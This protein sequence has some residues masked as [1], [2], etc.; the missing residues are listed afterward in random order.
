MRDVE[1]CEERVEEER[2]EGKRGKNKRK[3][4]TVFPP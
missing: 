1:R 2:G 4:L 3:L